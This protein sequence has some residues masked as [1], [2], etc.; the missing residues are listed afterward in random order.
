MV[1][2]GAAPRLPLDMI[3]GKGEY[4]KL[5]WDA[6]ALWLADQQ[7]VYKALRPWWSSMDAQLK[8]YYKKKISQAEQDLEKVVYPKSSL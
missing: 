6:L 3:C 2:G 7:A 8:I 4:P 1:I 5:H